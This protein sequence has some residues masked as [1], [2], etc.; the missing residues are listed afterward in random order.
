MGTWKGG[1][2]GV[3]SNGVC[4]GAAAEAEER[5]APTARR[6]V[7]L[8][9]TRTHSLIDG[10][11]GPAEERAFQSG[12]GEVASVDQQPHRINRMA[13][14]PVWNP[15]CRSPTLALDTRALPI[16]ISLYLGQKPLELRIATH[17]VQDRI[18]R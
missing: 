14:L 10:D 1:K 11:I 5:V 3:S 13:R 15:R 17:R 12:A 4:E 6:L 9:Y 18:H 8:G 16:H 7:Q 2:Q